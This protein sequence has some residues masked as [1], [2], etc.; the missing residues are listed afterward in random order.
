[1]KEMRL[2]RPEEARCQSALLSLI[3]SLDR[4]AMRWARGSKT[5]ILENVNFRKK[6]EAWRRTQF[7]TERPG[8]RQRLPC[9]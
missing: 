1:M 4:H 6:R 9:R 3:K 8:R 5:C 2:K 7:E